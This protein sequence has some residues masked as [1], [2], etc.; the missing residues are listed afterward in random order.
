M[1]NVPL[2]TLPSNC[3]QLAHKATS[4]QYKTP[5]AGGIPLHFTSMLDIIFCSKD[6]ATSVVQVTNLLDWNSRLV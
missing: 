1:L 5:S 3:L 6:Y 4:M 2:C